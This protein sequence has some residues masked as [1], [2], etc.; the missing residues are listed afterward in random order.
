MT[1]VAFSPFADEW[2]PDYRALLCSS[3]RVTL[4]A[5]VRGFI[6]DAREGRV[7]P[8]LGTSTAAHLGWFVADELRFSGGLWVVRGED[9]AIYDGRSGYRL[10]RLQDLWEKPVGGR[11][12][13]WSFRELAPNARGA[14]FF[15][16]FTR[17]RAQERTRCGVVAEHMVAGLGGGRLVRWG[18]CEPLANVW[19]R[20]DVT[21]SLRMQMPTS[22]RHLAR[23]EN[24]EPVSI[25]VS[26][27]RNGLLEHTRGLVPAGEYGKPEG[28]PEGA[29]LAMHPAITET[30]QGLVQGFRPNL[31][32]VS[33]S[34]VVDLDG[35]LGQ[36]VS[37]RRMD[38]PLAVLIGAP[39][40]R[41][42]QIDVAALSAHHDVTPLG[43][44]RAPS[45]LVRFSGRD[46][47]WHQLVAFAHD[48]DQ[49]RL[50]AAL[51]VEFDDLPPGKETK[52]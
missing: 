33:Y 16:V 2:G 19:N 14:F 43:L 37:R 15:D 29:P 13:L 8:I 12:R 23:G 3:E 26:R 35:S 31:A 39:A 17:E 44:R 45:L 24:G 28:L 41:D 47:L 25:Q 20:D 36:I 18:E 34:E 51:A 6:R 49:E 10:Q 11:E 7:K 21:Y 5:A 30:L 40:V 32:M 52:G 27:T 1:R 50:A 22:Q 38:V 4:T 46:E 42:L 9:G 48:L